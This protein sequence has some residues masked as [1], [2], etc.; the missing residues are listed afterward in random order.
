[1]VKAVVLYGPPEDA[2]AFERYYADT[3]T[4]LA[5]AIPGCS[6]SKPLGAS[7]RRTAVRS[8]IS[9]S[10]SSRS[11]TWTRFRR[12]SDPRRGRRPSTTFRTS[13]PAAS[14]SSSPK[15]TDAVA[16]LAEVGP[17]SGPFRR[18]ARR[19]ALRASPER[20]A[21]D[22]PSARCAARAS[23]GAGCGDTVARVG[24]ASTRGR[25]Q[26]GLASAAGTGGAYL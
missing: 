17:T 16:C 25:R 9:A 24:P 3:H 2:D 11:R 15:S 4:A 7:R 20:R 6:G 19:L 13:P 14:R 12:A 18:R 26:K 22:R 21:A 10:R 23:R 8:R 1:M 5:Q